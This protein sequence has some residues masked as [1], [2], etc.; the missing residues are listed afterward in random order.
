[1]EPIPTTDF[2]GTIQQDEI[3]L[4]EVSLDRPWFNRYMFKNLKFLSREKIS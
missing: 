1:M 4:R 2:K 3:S